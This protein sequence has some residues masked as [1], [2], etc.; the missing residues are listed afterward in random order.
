[1]LFSDAFCVLNLKACQVSLLHQGFFLPLSD[2]SALA[3]CNVAS[4]WFNGL[5]GHW[6][7]KKP[8]LRPGPWPRS[9]F[10]GNELSV[11]TSP[12]PSEG[13]C[14]G[15][16]ST[17]ACEF[18]KMEREQKT[19]MKK[20][21]THPKQNHRN[22]PWYNTKTL[23]RPKLHHQFAY[24]M[25]E[26]WV[27]NNWMVNTSKWTQST[28]LCILKLTHTVAPR[29]F[30]TFSL[31]TLHDWTCHLSSQK[32][33]LQPQGLPQH[34]QWLQ[35]P[36]YSTIPRQK[37]GHV[38]MKKSESINNKQQCHCRKKWIKKTWLGDQEKLAK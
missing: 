35:A 29:Q 16:Q 3:V 7:S 30:I 4:R 22:R 10:F 38:T 17:F 28:V 15:F 6:A 21:W 19:G 26:N 5:S 32:L 24:V 37:M 1:M 23:G 2:F 9:R 12:C 36:S 27:P 18:L 34:D 13:I 33:A 31:E 25:V 11:S 8:P 20:L 14:E